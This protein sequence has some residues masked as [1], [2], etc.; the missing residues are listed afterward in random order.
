MYKWAQHT[1][2][3]KMAYNDPSVIEERGGWKLRS[4][5]MFQ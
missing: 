2:N 5:N 1:I 4:L 3:I